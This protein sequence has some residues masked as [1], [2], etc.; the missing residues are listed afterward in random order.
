VPQRCARPVGS[1]HV[2]VVG[3]EITAETSMVRTPNVRPIM[4]NM[5]SK[6]S[7]SSTAPRSRIWLL[8]VVCE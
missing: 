6:S 5:M 1:E 2:K 7:G 4:T 3:P 8:A